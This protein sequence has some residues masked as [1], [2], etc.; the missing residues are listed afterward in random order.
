[1]PVPTDF[2]QTSD[3]DLD[4]SEGLRQTPDLV[5][6]VRQQLSQTVAFFQG[7]WFLDQRLGV[8]YFRYV[9][10][11]RPD[12]PLVQELMR[13]VISKTRGVGSVGQVALTL[14]PATRALEVHAPEVKTTDGDPVD[15]GPLIIG[16]L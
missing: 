2:L 5:T 15:P 4:F 14:D 12:F 1:M 6:F 13:R 16:D 7:E 8:P 3:G 9:L 10:G 11:K